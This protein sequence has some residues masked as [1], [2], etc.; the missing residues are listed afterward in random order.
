MTL[1][2]A[3]PPGA[4]L[5]GAPLGKRAGEARHGQPSAEPAVWKK[6]M[7]AALVQGVKGGKWHSLID[8][9]HRVATLRTAFAAVKANRGAAG[10]DHVSIEDHARDLD[11]N[12]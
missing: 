3:T 2:G 9:L 1:P 12:L 10:V 8:K 6:R 5:P 4:T 11:A 7:L